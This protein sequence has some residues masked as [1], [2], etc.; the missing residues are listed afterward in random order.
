MYICYIP[1]LSDLSHVCIRH[2]EWVATHL[3]PLVPR[4]TSHTSLGMVWLFANPAKPGPIALV[5]CGMDGGYP[6]VCVA[7]ESCHTIPIH[8]QDMREEWQPIHNH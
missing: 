5:V 6:C 8:Q 4:M 1:G 7:L 2:V 3:W